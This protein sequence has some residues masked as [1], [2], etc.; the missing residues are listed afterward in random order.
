MSKY[1]GNTAFYHKAVTSKIT[2]RDIFRDVFK[3]H[4][5]EDGEKMFIAGTVL[6]TPSESEMLYKWNKPWLFM[7]ILGFG[8]GIIALLY[9]L[10]FLGAEAY[11]TAPLMVIE[12]SLI[13]IVVLVL[14]WELNIPRNI[15]IYEVFYMVLAG[16]VLSLIFTAVIANIV[17]DYSNPCAAFV[18]EPAK[19]AAACIFLRKPKFRYIL[20][21]ILIG[22]AIGCGFAAIETIGYGVYDDTFLAGTYIM[23]G[24]LAPFGHIMYAAIYMG[25]LAG[26]KKTKKLSF[27]HLT[28]KKFLGFLMISVA[29]HFVWNITIDNFI[30]GIVKIIIVSIIGWA[31]LLYVIKMG[32]AEIMAISN[33]AKQIAAKGTCPV[34]YGISGIFANQTIP[35]TTGNVTFGRDV[36]QCNLV[37]P[38]DLTAIS[39]E[40]CTLSFDGQET[41]LTDNNSRN[42][43]FLENGKR[44]KTNEKIRLNKGQKFYLSSKAT[45]FELH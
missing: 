19:L 25:I 33:G 30:L 41:W 10:R 29:L 14:Y 23:R 17:G 7:R 27:E 38:P 20:N 43:T 9:I 1:D 6:T 31:V 13:P 44:L 28:N 24:L 3:K 37:F 42:G 40:H 5:K 16:G 15:P 32:V 18:E 45:M 4:R 39:R 21:G 2:V 36:N 22:G 11:T 34:L 26:I 35:L 8:L 12:G